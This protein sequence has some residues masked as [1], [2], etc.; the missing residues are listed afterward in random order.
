MALAT[1]W[2]GDHLPALAE[3]EGFGASPTDDAALLARLARLEVAEA[4][5]RLDEGHRPYIAC[6]DNE[7]VAY[8]WVATQRAHVGEIDLIITLPQGDRYLWDFATL[9]AWRGR[10]IYPRLLQTIL[11]AE[12]QEAARFWIIA[13]PENRASSAGI[14]KAGFTNIAHLSFQGQGQPALMAMGQAERVAAAAALLQVPV[15]DAEAQQAISP[16]WHCAID[17]RQ[18]R[19]PVAEAACWPTP[20]DFTVSACR[21]A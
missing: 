1:W 4:Q 12:Q 18:Q 9:A 15:L 2:R 20:N 8:G 11:R 16:C 10:G 21:C 3:V 13:A 17:A 14:G 6:L 5:R 7:P 19:R